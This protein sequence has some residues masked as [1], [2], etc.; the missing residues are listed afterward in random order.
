MEIKEKEQRTIKKAFNSAPS[1]QQTCITQV[2]HWMWYI[3]YLHCATPWYLV[4]IVVQNMILAFIFT[5]K[6]FI[7]DW[8]LNLGRKK[9]RNKAFVLGLYRTSRP[10]RKSDKFS[11][12]GLSGSW[13][14]SFPDAGLLTL[15]K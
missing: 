12:S 15:L 13:M 4:L 11:K 7:W 9:I 2:L 3:W 14:S 6:I 10:V 8:D 5:S 1:R